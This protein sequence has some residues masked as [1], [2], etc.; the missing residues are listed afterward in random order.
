MAKMNWSRPPA[1]QPGWSIDAAMRSMP[2]G[3]AGKKS[4]KERFG[5][6]SQYGGFCTTCKARYEIGD[7]IKYN[8]HNDIVHGRGCPAK[9]KPSKTP[10]AE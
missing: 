4:N 6:T 9:A 2:K 8:V 7:Y 5:F 1:R 10:L 3:H